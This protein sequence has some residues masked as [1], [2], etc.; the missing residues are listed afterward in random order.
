MN[1]VILSGN[2]TRNPELQTTSGG[3]SLC[4][5]SVAVQDIALNANGEKETDFF[6]ITA[7]RG[8]ADNCGKYLAKGSKVLVVGKLKN[9]TYDGKDGAKKYV[10]EITANEV[11]FLSKTKRDDAEQDRGTEMYDDDDGLPF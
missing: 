4:K 9:K 1:K 11:E 10:T 5:F 7:W 8:L 6:N 3:V 2:L